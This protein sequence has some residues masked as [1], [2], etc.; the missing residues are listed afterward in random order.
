MKNERIK[1]SRKQLDS[2]RATLQKIRRRKNATPA[3]KALANL[4]LSALDVPD[5][6]MK[7]AQNFPFSR[8]KGR[9]GDEKA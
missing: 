4:A 1:P 8:K 2:Y 9:I 7:S 6:I 3:Q 5:E